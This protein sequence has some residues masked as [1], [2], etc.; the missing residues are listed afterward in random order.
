MKQ[1]SA[2][3][4]SCSRC[5]ACRSACDCRAWW[6]AE[7]L[8]P[9]STQREHAGFL[10]WSHIGIISA[11][12]PVAIQL[13]MMGVMLTIVKPRVFPALLFGTN[14][15]RCSLDGLAEIP[16]V[17]GALMLPACYTAIPCASLCPACGKHGFPPSCLSQH[18]KKHGGHN[19]LLMEVL[20]FTGQRH[21][22][23]KS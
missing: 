23:Y 1:H 13:E 7:E 6:A 19:A 9:M 20:Y 15:F 3:G 5:N 4:P 18:A 11:G 22:L 14:W 8:L 17:I 21:V 10:L 16:A 12:T 2:S